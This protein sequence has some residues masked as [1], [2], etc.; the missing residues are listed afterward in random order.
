[1]FDTFLSSVCLINYEFLCRAADTNALL[2]RTA[3]A[4]FGILIA[5]PFN[6]LNDKGAFHLH[7]RDYKSSAGWTHTLFHQVLFPQPL[8]QEIVSRLLI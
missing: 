3:E 1:M 6:G 8:Y 2:D 4:L 5:E 7:L